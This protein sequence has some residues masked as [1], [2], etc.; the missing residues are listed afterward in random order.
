MHLTFIFITLLLRFMQ[1]LPI[2]KFRER[3][4]RHCH[5]NYLPLRL[6]YQKAY[7]SPVRQRLQKV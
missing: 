4:Y 5:L 7:F 1:M 2:F 3:C 6:Y